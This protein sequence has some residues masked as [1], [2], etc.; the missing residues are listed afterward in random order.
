MQEHNI[1]GL[2]FF[3]CHNKSHDIVSLRQVNTTTIE[4]DWEIKLEKMWRHVAVMDPK[5]HFS[6][7]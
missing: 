7:I 6:S 4:V 3:A 1:S 5:E 2:T